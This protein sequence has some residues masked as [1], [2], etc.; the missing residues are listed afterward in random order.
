MIYVYYW[1][2]FCIYFV[3]EQATLSVT[4]K[5]NVLKISYQQIEQV[6]S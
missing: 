2:A 3:I 6:N 5:K 4:L 1:Q